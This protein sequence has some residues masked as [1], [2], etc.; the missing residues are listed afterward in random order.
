MKTVIIHGQS[1]EGSTCMAARELADKVGGETKEFFLPR[2][3]DKHCTGC[4]ICYKTGISNCPHYNE[5]APVKSAILDADLIIL[6]SPVYVYHAPGQMMSLLDHLFTWWVVHRPMPE[7]SKKQA[8]AISTAA[9]GGMKS[10]NRDMA[11][12][13]EMWGIHKVYRLGFG[14]QALKP[15][16]IP[17]RIMKTIHRKTDRLAGRIRKNAGSRGCNMRAKKWFYLMRLAHKMFKPDDPDYAYW[18]EKG[19]HGKGR[20]WKGA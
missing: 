14:V 15:G 1:H 16:E 20:P 3:F 2:D 18:E 11:D 4:C 19:W 10:T 9:G 7:M 8:V 12:S 13:L 17:E 5:L 6:A